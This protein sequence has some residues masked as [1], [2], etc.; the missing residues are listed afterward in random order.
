MAE[1][2]SGSKAEDEQ[3]FSRPAQHQE[4]L[5]RETSQ[6]GAKKQAGVSGWMTVLELAFLDTGSVRHCREHFADDHSIVWVGGKKVSR[7]TGNRE[8]VICDSF[9]ARLGLPQK[10]FGDGMLPININITKH[11]LFSALLMVTLLPNL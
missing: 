2:C 4:S 1:L 3:C 6:T 10:F 9:L 7:I 8:N 5:L 11:V